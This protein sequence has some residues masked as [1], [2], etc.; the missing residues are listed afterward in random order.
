MSSIKYIKKLQENWMS[1]VAES[2]NSALKGTLNK[3][4]RQCYEEKKKT[5]MGLVRM[6]WRRFIIFCA[7]DSRSR[8]AGWS[9]ASSLQSEIFLVEVSHEVPYSFSI[10]LRRHCKPAFPLATFLR[11]L[12]RMIKLLTCN[13]YTKLYQVSQSYTWMDI[14]NFLPSQGLDL[15]SPT[16]IKQLRIHSAAK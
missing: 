8:S 9:Q 12:K 14:G 10:C 5:L 3:C 4:C 7:S 11:S 1:W 13:L 6:D 16:I 15:H 2:N